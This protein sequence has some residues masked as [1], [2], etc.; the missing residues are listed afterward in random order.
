MT[1]KT[2]YDETDSGQTAI[3]VQPYQ[4]AN[5]LRRLYDSEGLTQRE[6]AEMFDVDRSTISRWMNEYEIDT[7]RD[8]TPDSDEGGEK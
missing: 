4:D 5:R 1:D 3:R 2:A 6:I 7:Q 8:R